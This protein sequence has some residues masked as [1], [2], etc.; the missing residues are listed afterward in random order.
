MS[1]YGFH[2]AI[3][4]LREM[5]DRIINSPQMSSSEKEFQCKSLNALI[6]LVQS[7]YHVA[8]HKDLGVK[9]ADELEH[10]AEQMCAR[11]EAAFGMESEDGRWN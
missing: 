9:T 4:L 5:Q 3:S 6:D 8:L 10:E 7:N 2:T 1:M 11:L